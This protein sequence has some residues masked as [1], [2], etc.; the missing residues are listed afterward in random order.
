MSKIRVMITQIGERGEA[1]PVGALP[2]LQRQ[3]QLDGQLVAALAVV[4]EQGGQIV[5]YEIRRLETNTRSGTLGC[6]DQVVL[7]SGTNQRRATAR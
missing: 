4:G 6:F 3:T 2:D 7:D 1:G 5:E